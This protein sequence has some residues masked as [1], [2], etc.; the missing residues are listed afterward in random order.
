MNSL[1]LANTKRVRH[2][3]QI[4]NNE[5]VRTLATL[6]FNF[7][8]I[9]IDQ[10]KNKIKAH[11]GIT[12]NKISV[13]ND[14]GQTVF[15]KAIADFY[16]ISCKS[17]KERI[18]LFSKLYVEIS[19]ENEPVVKLFCKKESEISE[20]TTAI[21]NCRDEIIKI[22]TDTYNEALKFFN[23]N[24]SNA[25]KHALTKF[26]SIPNWL[27]ANAYI[28]KCKIKIKELEA[29]EEAE[30]KDK[31]YS[32]ALY[33]FK[34]ETIPALLS[35]IAEFK[36]IIDWK[37]S[38]DKITDC[39]KALDK[40]FE[41]AVCLMEG[42]SVDKLQEAIKKFDL[43]KDFKN[44]K[45]L[46]RQCSRKIEEIKTAIENER[47]SRIYAEAIEISKED[48]ISSID[49]ALLLLK[50]IKGWNDVD[51]LAKTLS[52]RK[53]E[54]ER[55][56]EENRKNK[57]YQE[58]LSLLNT[59]TI[60]SVEKAIKLFDNIIDWK[61][62]KQQIIFCEKQLKKIY[63]AEFWNIIEKEKET[64]KSQEEVPTKY[65][66]HFSKTTKAGIELFIHNPYYILGISC[67]SSQ[68]DALNVKDK[69]EKFA[70]LK[71]TNAYK[72][73]FDLKHIE[74]PTRDIGAIQSAIVA[75]KE[76]SHKWLW[77]ADGEYSYWWDS[78]KIFEVLEK[79]EIENINYEILLAAYIQLV[80]VDGCFSR[81][82]NWDHLLSVI[83]KILCLPTMQLITIL[84]NH[85]GDSASQETIGVLAE[86][87]KKTFL[88]PFYKLCENADKT[89]IINLGKCLKNKFKSKEL[90]DGLAAALILNLT[91][92]CYPLETF[93]KDFPEKGASVEEKDKLLELAKETE[94]E[95]YDN[96]GVLLSIV[97]D[98]STYAK[99][100]KKKYKDLYWDVTL[101]LLNNNRKATC[102]PFIKKI[103]G[104]CDEGD[105]RR[106]RNTYG[107][108]E[109][110][111]SENDLSP[112]E[113]NALAIE[114]DENGE[115]S[116]SI[117][118]FERA[119][120]AGNVDAQSNL[121]F[122]YKD[123]KGV[124]RNIS[125]AI[126]WWKKSANAGNPVAQY[127]LSQVYMEDGYNQNI[128]EAMQWLRKACDQNFEPAM[129]IFNNIVEMAKSYNYQ[130]RQM[131]LSLLRYMGLD[132]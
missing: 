103:Y 58:A 126:T 88:S 108:K 72:S 19:I 36:K 43:L 14:M 97:G 69:I 121:A 112:D 37:D 17:G 66:C 11:C 32:D 124:S 45:D 98:D 76:L 31:I 93:L 100:I 23:K 41:E 35:A 46:S 28:A 38:K 119:A 13:Q 39:E 115:I 101:K 40:F 47:K 82:E 65:K 96:I 27:D 92:R 122:R 1:S 102:I 70:R 52:N 54:L 9:Y 127:M 21:S 56:A 6:N 34:K 128:R 26:T 33:C 20:I 125:T 130:D 131:A 123:G 42:N 106:L 99:R 5:G 49:K 94:N 61:D 113:W 104:F 18:G 84:K 86:S 81:Q 51:T 15:E 78:P 109:L 87:F 67:R 64:C 50:E 117:Y 3:C 111:V 7:K 16:Y 2:A 63:D 57:L 74:K 60:E 77:F 90:T 118:W 59:N 105:Q 24:T 120:K 83:D 79:E 68:N 4:I 30:R 10:N 29:K 116:K 71:M 89:Q 75:I 25:C 48:T 8:A 73:V 95:V 107:Y 114:C 129:N 62:S 12:Q 132:V 110:G 44:A 55:I 22:R 85:I 91:N 80:I 53:D